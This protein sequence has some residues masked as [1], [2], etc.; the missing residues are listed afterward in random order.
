MLHILSKQWYLID[1]AVSR[2]LRYCRISGNEFNLR[3]LRHLK[4]I[5]TLPRINDTN[6]GGM[7][8]KSTKE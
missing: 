8:K 6:D 1:L 5:Q 7:V 2:M 4:P 3:I